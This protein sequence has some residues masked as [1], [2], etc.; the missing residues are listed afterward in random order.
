MSQIKELVVE[1]L[2]N[3]PRPHTEHVI[4]DVF[5]Y[6]E[7]NGSCLSEYNTLCSESS[8]G[9]H[10]VNPS[11]GRLVQQIT[12]R[13]VLSKGNES[14]KSTLIKSYSELAI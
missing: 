6:I 1:A 13:S 8:S 2:E 11:I 9:K 7:Q 3:L 10:G 5:L 14:V 12:D 4:H